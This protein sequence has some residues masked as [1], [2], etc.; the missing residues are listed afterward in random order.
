MWVSWI[1]IY[2]IIFEHQWRPSAIALLFFINTHASSAE[3]LDCWSTIWWTGIQFVKEIHVP[4]R[5]DPTDSGNPL[6]YTVVPLWGWYFWLLS[7]TSPQ[8]AIKLCSDIHVCPDNFT[9]NNNFA[10]VLTFIL[11]P[12]SGQVFILFHTFVYIQIP[13]K[14]YTIPI[15]LSYTL[16][17]VPISKC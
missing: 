8:I 17:L 12:S 7:Q 14:F 11:V 5:M 6:I 3:I 13:A 1:W 10:D 15:S 2:Y 16:F 9:I 4:Q